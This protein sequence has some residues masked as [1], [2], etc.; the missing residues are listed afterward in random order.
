MEFPI[1]I[2]DDL[3]ATLHTDAQRAEQILKNLLANAFKFT[4]RGTRDAR[5]PP[6]AEEM[7][8]Q[9]A[10][11]DYRNAIAFSVIDT[12]IGI[13]PSKFKDIFEAFQQENGS[14]DRHY[15]G[16]GLGLT[17]ARKFAH[18]LGGEIHVASQKGKG[19]RFTLVLPVNLARGEPEEMRRQRSL[20][21][22]TA[23]HRAQTHAPDPD[24]GV[25]RR[26]PP[27]YRSKGQGAADHRGRPGL[28][29][30]L[31]EDRA[32]AQL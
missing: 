18:M 5:D 31:D 16:T 11:L 6:A 17:I 25:Y 21:R 14:I 29:G 24:G 8:L 7:E 2:A 20:P 19:S 28:R 10:S 9:R 12:G 23:P 27:Q 26:R 3:P 32:Q 22:G 4:E 1:Q 15:G 13:E 30:H